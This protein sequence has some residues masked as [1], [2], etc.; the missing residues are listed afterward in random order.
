MANRKPVVHDAMIDSSLSYLVFRIALEE[1]HV[2]HGQ[3]VNITVS[4]KLLPHSRSDHGDWQ[5]HIV[6]GLDLGRLCCNVR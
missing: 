1:K 2:H 4:L 5:R 3:L 6:H